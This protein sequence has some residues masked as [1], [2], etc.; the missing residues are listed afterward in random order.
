MIG[1]KIAHYE[2][3]EKIGAGGMGEVYKARDT[4]LER[5][6]AIKI[7]PP[8]MLSDS[9][10]KQRFIR[11]ARA[12]SSLNH[13]NII[14]VHDIA[15]EEGVDFM[16]MEFVA[17]KTLG[18]LI[19]R[20]GLKVD[21][22]LKYGVEIAGALA[23]AH[24]A[25]IVHRDLKPGNVMVSEAGAIK[26]LDFGLAKLVD[27]APNELATTETLQPATEEG[28]IVGTVAYMSPEQAEGKKLDSRS[29][30]FSFGL[31]LYEMFAGRRAFQADSRAATFAAILQQEPKPISSTREDIHPDLE[32]LIGRCLRKD[33]QRRAQSM[34]DIRLSLEDMRDE[35]REGKLRTSD[36][37]V[38]LKSGVVSFWPIALVAV[39]AVALVMAFWPIPPRDPAQLIP[40]ATEFDVQTMPRWSPKG[41]RI[42][43]VAAVNSVLQ[44]FTKSL[45]SSVSTQ[46]THEKRG[47]LNPIWSADGTRIY[48]LTG[49][50]PNNSMRSIAVAGG[51]S[52]KVLDHVT[53]A[54]LSPDGKTMAV[55]AADSTG[56]YRLALSSPPQS[57]PQPYLKV[58]LSAF[59]GAGS[60][61]YLRFD[62]SSKHLGLLTLAAGGE[63]WNIPQD[64]GEPEEIMQGKG[65]LL[66][67]HFDWL[68]NG[69]G[70]VSDTTG[71][72][73][74]RLHLWTFN[75]SSKAKRII[76]AGVYRDNFPSLSPDGRIL[77]FASGE[78]KFDIIQVP[79][80]GSAT[81][82]VIA[83]SRQELG[84]AWAPDGIHFAYVTD[85][86]GTPEIWLRNQT[87]GSERRIAGSTEL[88]DVNYFLDCAI[89]PD[90]TRIAY[91]AH[92]GGEIAIWI[93]PLT[94]DLPVK[95]WDD[96]AKSPQRGPSWSPDGNWI[97]Y[98]GLHG[99]KTAVM[100]IRVGANTPGESVAD[101]ATL[102]LAHWSPRGDWIVFRDGDVLRIVSPDGKQN[103]VINQRS[104]ET[105]GW[106]KEGSALYGIA[107]GEDHRL[108]LGKIE[109]ANGKES[110]I[111]DL[112]PIPPAFDLADNFNE[113][114]YR[115]FSLNPDGKSFLTSALRSKM[116]IYLMKDFNQPIRLADQ[117]KVNNA[118][119][120]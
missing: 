87:D 24:A 62:P 37:M 36:S 61:T 90:G 20:R 85:R 14:T 50:K 76:T 81:H 98:S 54:D 106:S 22:G 45:G 33:T 100:K 69:K 74:D 66:V 108:V 111:A 9:D 89:S 12:A 112:G 11:E 70:I 68:R 80:D 4:H 93:S 51:P 23:A 88:P 109:V 46:I 1:R 64:G 119:R 59:A 56:L 26:V 2:I 57:A 40:F 120:Y 63:F 13:P 29:D 107:S 43:Y 10:R 48:Y 8:Q 27:P 53:Q 31:V 65:G 72:S 94:G 21:E 102:Q 3:L 39:T 77:A 113:Y 58:P 52:E 18:Q 78:L 34:A 47:C 75:W 71:P 73:Q 118:N 110:Q 67:G 19:G 116:Q 83:T 84:P 49:T 42:A 60:G 95:L 25:G 97:A 16:V 5:V 17:G 99:G 105:Y 55:L 96:P 7:L 32:K 92:V 41:D 114:P 30:I 6:V 101:M 35:F 82:D 86:A 28:L 91:R 15:C 38:A 104:W 44:V 103:R 117:W 79:L 115:G